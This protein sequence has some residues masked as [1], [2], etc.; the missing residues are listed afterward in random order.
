[1]ADNRLDKIKIH[2]ITYVR[3]DKLRTIA[4]TPKAAPFSDIQ[5]NKV[6]EVFSKLQ[7]ADKNAAMLNSPMHQ[8]N[9][10]VDFGRPDITYR[11]YC[12]IYENGG[13]VFAFDIE[14]NNTII[15]GIKQFGVTE[16]GIHGYKVPAKAMRQSESIT[17]SSSWNAA[18]RL[19]SP[20]AAY[21]KKLLDSGDFAS[22]SEGDA[23][24][25]S[26]LASYSGAKFGPDGSIV[27]K[28]PIRVSPRHVREWLESS[29]SNVRAARAGLEAL[30][31]HGLPLSQAAAQVNKY[32][33]DNTLPGMPVFSLGQGSRGF[34]LPILQRAGF[35]LPTDHIDMLELM[36][37]SKEAP[38]ILRGA[39]DHI[40]M[41]YS[42]SSY[43]KSVLGHEETHSAAADAEL[44]GTLFERSIY[45]TD[46][47]SLGKKKPIRQ[48]FANPVGAAIEADKLYALRSASTSDGKVLFGGVWENVSKSKNGEIKW[49]LNKYNT[50]PVSKYSMYSAYTYDMPVSAIPKDMAS[51]LAEEHGIASDETLKVLKLTEHGGDYVS[52][53]VFRNQD[54]LEGFIQHTFGRPPKNGAAT[55]ERQAH[56]IDQARRQYINT[57][58]DVAKF[59][60]YTKASQILKKYVDTM[61]AAGERYSI[62]TFNTIDE[63]VSYWN[64]VVKKVG[65]KNPLN[66][67]SQIRDFIMLGDRYVSEAMVRGELLNELP[68]LEDSYSKQVAVRR[69]YHELKSAGALPKPTGVPYASK[70]FILN[71]DEELGEQYYTVLNRWNKRDLIRGINN[72]I[73][74]SGAKN[75]GAVNRRARL[76]V[77]ELADRGVV[78]QSVAKTLLDMTTGRGIVTPTYI[79][80][81]LA[82]AI[83]HGP[84]QDMPNGEIPETIMGIP[85]RGTVEDVRSRIRTRAANGAVERA[86]SFTRQFTSGPASGTGKLTPE[87]EAILE[88][89]Q[90][91]VTKRLKESLGVTGNIGE[92][93]KTKTGA[94]IMI[95]VPNMKDEVNKLMENWG[96]HGFSTTLSYDRTSNT[97]LVAA[98]RKSIQGATDIAETISSGKVVRFAI[99]LSHAEG[100]YTIGGTRRMAPFFLKEAKGTTHRFTDMSV[101]LTRR[102][103]N[104]ARLV[105]EKLE[106]GASYTE[107]NNMIQSLPGKMFMEMTNLDSDLKTTISRSGDWMRTKAI[108]FGDVSSFGKPWKDIGWDKKMA[109]RELSEMMWK[110]YGITTVPFRESGAGHSMGILYDLV[111]HT[112]I[113][114]EHM[115]LYSPTF[116]QTANILNAGEFRVKGGYTTIEE[117]IKNNENILLEKSGKLGEYERPLLTAFEQKQERTGSAKR[118]MLKTVY[119]E[120]AMLHELGLK[121][122]VYKGNIIV[123]KD[124]AKI[125]VATGHTKKYKIPWENLD[126]EIQARL[127]TEEYSGSRFLELSP[128]RNGGYVYNGNRM[129][130][131]GKVASESI[132]SNISDPTNYRPITHKLS[133]DVYTHIEYDKRTQTLMLRTIY[134]T[135]TA[136]KLFAGSDKV[137]PTFVDMN[138]IILRAREKF[139]IDLTGV[140]AITSA[141]EITKKGAWDTPVAS[142]MLYGIKSG[143]DRGIELPEIQKSLRT[144]FGLKTTI[145][146]RGRLISR[147]YD[148][149]LASKFESDEAR[150]A[151]WFKSMGMSMDD[152]L[153][154]TT[155]GNELFM[156]YT[157]FGMS[158]VFR[159]M[160]AYG[161][162]LDEA[163]KGIY[164]GK[165]E[166]DALRKLKSDITDNI[167]YRGAEQTIAYIQGEIQRSPEFRN[168]KPSQWGS[169]W[170]S[171]LESLY[172]QDPTVSIVT[173]TMTGEEIGKRIL[174][175]GRVFN[176]KGGPE[177]LVYSRGSYIPN[178]PEGVRAIPVSELH[179]IE[180]TLNMGEPIRTHVGDAVSDI[181]RV[182]KGTVYDPRLAGKSGGWHLELPFPVTVGDEMVRKTVS[183]MYMIGAQEVR[184]RIFNNDALRIADALVGAINTF[185]NPEAA[186][187]EVTRARERIPQL[188]NQYYGE[189]W[190]QI[191]SKDSKLYEEFLGG[192]VGRSAI[193]TPKTENVLSNLAESNTV[194]ISRQA[195]ATMLEGISQADQIMREMEHG[196]GIPS[197][198]G[199]E[200]IFHR[201]AQSYVRTKID[202]NIEKNVIMLTVGQEYIAQADNDGDPIRLKLLLGRNPDKYIE[203]LHTAREC[204]DRLLATNPSQ[205]E[206]NKRLQQELYRYRNNADMPLII[207]SIL[208]ERAAKRNTD[209]V[210]LLIAGE[211]TSKVSTNMLK[212]A[213]E[214]KEQWD[215]IKSARSNKTPE[216]RQL[217]MMIASEQNMAKELYI[218]RMS[219]INLRIKTFVDYVNEYG[220]DAITVGKYVKNTLGLATASASIDSYSNVFKALSDTA[221]T[222]AELLYDAASKIGGGMESNVVTDL[223][224][225]IMQHLGEGT[226]Q[227][228]VRR[229]YDKLGSLFDA[230]QS[231]GWKE[232]NRLRQEFLKLTPERALSIDMQSITLNGQIDDI[233][234]RLVDVYGA[235]NRD[236]IESTIKKFFSISGSNMTLGDYIDYIDKQ[237]STIESSMSALG[238]SMKQVFG[239]HMPFMHGRESATGTTALIAAA[240]MEGNMPVVM[241]PTDFRNLQSFIGKSSEH[242]AEVEETLRYRANIASAAMREASTEAKITNE[243]VSDSARVMADDILKSRQRKINVPGGKLIGGVMAASLAAALFA[244]EPEEKTS[245]QAQAEDVQGTY[246][247]LDPSLLPPSSL[248]TGPTARITTNTGVSRIHISV[249]D[250]KGIS[251]AQ[252]NRIVEQYVRTPRIYNSR[253][254]NSARID[255]QWTED[256]IRK[257]MTYGYT[258]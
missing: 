195:A 197:L 173:D 178:L 80:S 158:D 120:D 237:Y 87:G 192:Y 179:S 119:M 37:Q 204:V 138:P 133:G 46:R 61:S 104:Y 89:Y 201:G 81:K 240:Q 96:R 98:Q 5:E 7:A 239:Q 40:V 60:K 62:P 176:K 156:G 162:T 101:E 125:L 33:A 180:G 128:K 228:E 117:A 55:V 106:S 199:R 160:R 253:K 2:G 226:T 154:K 186:A 137:M 135:S 215:Y 185:Q 147:G 14:G 221:S 245:G 175:S 78:D 210:T 140:R 77:Q 17:K 141:S 103:A 139:G 27:S 214:Q 49:R 224:K 1:M 23:W 41:N 79:S 54:D 34:D 74:G 188:V 109:A 29:A 97:L 88:K 21:Y 171:P 48:M 258:F 114:Q 251:Q 143:V 73:Y 219:N 130:T 202:P 155:S 241:S 53:M 45:K 12:N 166:L 113:G 92:I 36:T 22:L 146:S 111:K 198:M 31:R 24:A 257:A 220:S 238:D 169:L 145:D 177:T 203:N 225:K 30:Q 35:N 94:R 69:L 161:K 32:I 227:E 234:N 182:I 47:L 193:L 100:Y 39:A 38:E 168:V 44:V 254:D 230:Y 174:R 153:L 112:R 93:V 247:E 121:E 184:G 26:T 206:F 123:D 131:V 72:A 51:K 134:D 15:G 20:Q 236:E 255:R 124:V 82:Y 118:F 18:V 105:A 102:Y 248:G 91:R 243:I 66:T 170:Y 3:S 218:G 4:V 86:L 144:H 150:W 148:F 99:P 16:I 223:N 84:S 250:P 165:R 129:V 187:S 183:T 164:F 209:A 231:G 110:T 68:T 116:W 108:F 212:K 191:F 75:I 233:R 25:I 50:Y 167:S 159:Y 95:S 65:G 256:K 246:K 213:R 63:M 232:G 172:K 149:R 249:S 10:N 83:Q 205:A 194:K 207:E 163:N 56:M 107:V 208:K 126:P 229:L 222:Q 252:L 122:S 142:W 242:I 13:Q 211:E 200:P 8:I 151:N 157:E 11:N 70:A 190:R 9:A 90:S 19:S 181:G 59:T 132:A 152:A 216:M 127:A 115:T 71:V 28:G 67:R 76:I 85:V 6:D 235:G 244:G 196:E 43:A 136:S 52:R 58:S 42:L 64:D 189:V 57:W 217:E